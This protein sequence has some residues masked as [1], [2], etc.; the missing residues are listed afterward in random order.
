VKVNA[1]NIYPICDVG[2]MIYFVLAI[3][4]YIAVIAFAIIIVLETLILWRMKWGSFKKSFFVSLGLNT[5]SGIAGY[6]LIRWIG[7]DVVLEILQFQ[8]WKFLF[9]TWLLTVCIEG[10][11]LILLERENWQKSLW[12]AVIIN[13]AS[14][15]WNAIVLQSLLHLF[16]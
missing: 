11:I 13:I 8:F 12:S 4:L 7:E 10:F 3:V 1:M 2:G 16:T 6:F 15:I 9:I 5:V 14:Y